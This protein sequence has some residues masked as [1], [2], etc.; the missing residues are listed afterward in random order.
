MNI[1]LDLALSKAQVSSLV[2]SFVHDA[3]I[4]SGLIEVDKLQ[5]IKHYKKFQDSEGK[6]AFRQKI[7][8]GLLR[9]WSKRFDSQQAEL[10]WESFARLST[11]FENYGAVIFA[12]MIE[13]SKF[14][15]LV[16]HYDN[17]LETEKSTSRVQS[18][19]NLCNYP[20]FV[21]NPEF[22]DA[23]LSPLLIT[24]IAYMVGGAIRVIHARGKNAEPIAN[25][26][27][28]NIQDN[29]LHV[30]DLPF[31]DEYKV[32][33]TW[34]TSKPSGPKGLNFAFIPGTHK[35]VRDCLINEHE[36]VWTPEDASLFI[37]EDSIDGLLN[38]QLRNTDITS[39]MVVEARHDTK[40]LTVAFASGSLVHHRYGTS[41]KQ[42]ARSSIVVAFQR[43]VDHPGAIITNDQCLPELAKTDKLYNLLFAHHENDVDKQFLEG[44]LDNSNELA[45]VLQDINQSIDLIGLEKMALSHEELYRWKYKTLAAPTAE[46]LKRTTI[47]LPMGESL[48]LDQFIVLIKQ[49]ILLDKHGPL[50]LILYHDNHEEARKWARHRIKDINMNYLDT[51]FKFWQSH[52]KLPEINNLLSSTQ[53]TTIYSNLIT[54]VDT[55]DQ[56][57]AQLA[58]TEAVSI[59]YI[60]KS[61]KQLLT[62]L[63]ESILR[64]DTK[65][66]YLST[67]LFIF[68]VINEL[69]VLYPNQAL[70]VTDGATLLNHYI[71]ANLVVELQINYENNKIIS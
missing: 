52:I 24:L 32:I 42:F 6:H 25:A 16:R 8:Q 9:A 27:L 29:W 67:S 39:P 49:I 20:D 33:L 23:F 59:T 21:T 44:V 61:L 47:K 35:G 48:S 65:Q 57:N 58:K 41:D 7:Q 4:K 43:T 51:H 66:S 3:K 68:L 50:N 17:V 30:D 70:L 64:C 53:L 31:N 11:Q 19:T 28:D 55:I 12:D 2:N 45:V 54:F 71:V 62:D 36:E 26:G 13:N 46:S 60:H 22:K 1:K 40:P 69:Q 56:S 15:Q 5:H 18:Y 34:E 38:F 14:Q 37:T 63:H 10:L